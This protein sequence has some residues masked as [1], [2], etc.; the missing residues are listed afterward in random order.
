MGGGAA[1]FIGR[2]SSIIGHR[3]PCGQIHLGPPGLVKD[4]I[5]KV[6]GARISRGHADVELVK[7]GNELIKVRKG[8]VG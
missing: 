4:S 1:W 3:L 6:L 5:H 7:G 8:G 2:G